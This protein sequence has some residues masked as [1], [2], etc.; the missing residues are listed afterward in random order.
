M[1]RDMGSYRSRVHAFFFF[2]L[3]PEFFAEKLDFN[4]FIQRKPFIDAND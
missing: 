1:F 2:R 3:K 4:D